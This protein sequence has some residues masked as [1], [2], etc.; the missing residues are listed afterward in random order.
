MAEN[1]SNDTVIRLEDQG[2]IHISEDVVASIAS[3]AA[4]ETEGVVMMAASG[5][6]GVADL[7][8][9]KSL[10]RGVK[11]SI[12]EN[13]VS[14]D[15]YVMIKYGAAIPKVAVKIQEGIKS[16]VESM[17]GLQVNDV[18]VHVGGVSFDKEKK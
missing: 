15:V 3:L 1:K 12:T 9:K 16:S 2:S 18:H 6:G 4:A 8:G 7:L 5:A 17:T 11:I 14:A 10:S 13:A